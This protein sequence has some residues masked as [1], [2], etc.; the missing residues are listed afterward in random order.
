MRRGE[1]GFTV[2]EILVAMAIVALVAHAATITTFQV[3]HSS[4]RSNSYLTAMQQVQNAG[5]WISR[6]AQMAES[7]STDNLS[8]PN[9]VII[10]WTERN[11]GDEP[12]Y[13]S[14]T[15]FF[16]DLSD[17]IGKLKRNYW[18]SVGTNENKL[19]ADYIYFNQADPDNT[20]SASYLKPELAVQ[21]VA[22]FGDVQETREY[23]VNRRQTFN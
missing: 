9:L 10:N 22:Q 14:A 12:I 19:V 18:N 6:D 13:H 15:Y 2:I 3:I 7:I 8:F 17:G 20:S 5:Y 4:E 21:L 1:K 11:Y 16:A 23:R